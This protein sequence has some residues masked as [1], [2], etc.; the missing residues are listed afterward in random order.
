MPEPA[1]D[2]TQ[3]ELLV[4]YFNLKSHVNNV[5]DDMRNFKAENRQQLLRT[6]ALEFVMKPGSYTIREKDL[7]ID[8]VIIQAEKLFQYMENGV[9]GDGSK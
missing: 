5:A 4:A 1:Q 2:M 7:T 6:R 3:Q 9:I 8:D